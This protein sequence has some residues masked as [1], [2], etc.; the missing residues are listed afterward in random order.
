MSDIRNLTGE[1]TAWTTSNRKTK[2][3]IITVV[4]TT[5]REVVEMKIS[6]YNPEIIWR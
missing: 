4:L 2:E 1:C 5:T 3:E 6:E